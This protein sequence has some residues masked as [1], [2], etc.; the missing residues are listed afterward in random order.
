MGPQRVKTVVTRSY[1]MIRLFGRHRQDQSER[2]LV[3]VEKLAICKVE[4][5]VESLSFV[6]FVRFLLEYRL[7]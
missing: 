3:V 6:V 7:Y 2:M 4:Y 1:F 5:A